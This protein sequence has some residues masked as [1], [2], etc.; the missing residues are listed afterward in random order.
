[1][2]TQRSRPSKIASPRAAQDGDSGSAVRELS[3]FAAR[4]DALYAATRAL[5]EHGD[6]EHA[7]PDL[8]RNV[9]SAL[10]WDI[11]E[12]WWRDPTREQLD[13]MG[14]WSIPELASTAFVRDTSAVNPPD[15]GLIGKVWSSGKAAWSQDVQSSSALVRAKDA[16]ESGLRSAFAF[17]ICLREDV[18]GVIAFF[19]RASRVPDQN[20]I[21]M[22]ENLGSQIGLLYERS[23]AESAIAESERRYRELVSAI[24]V[25]VYTT[26][27]E[28]RIT[29][30]NSEAEEL[31][32]R[33]PELGKDQWCGSW[34]L[35]WPDG[36]QMKHEE[37]PLAVTL[38]EQKPVTGAEIVVERSDGSRRDVL[39]HPAPLKDARGN[40]VGAVNVLID[41]SERKA[42]ERAL[43]A[44]EK[45]LRLAMEAGGLGAWEWDVKT[46]EVR[47]SATLERI[48]GIPEGSFGGT[49]EDYQRDIHPGD[50]EMVK[51]AISRS[52]Q[53]GSHELSY[54]V[55][56]PDGEVR[57]L[58]AR[59]QLHRDALG[60]P[61]RLVGVCADITDRRE[62]QERRARLAA[63]VESSDDAIIGKDLDGTITSWN[64][65]A[66]QTYGYTADE[67]IGKN[68]T[69][70]LP[71]ESRA[72]SAEILERVKRGGKVEH[73]QTRRRCKDGRI[74]DVAVTISPIRDDSGRIVGASAINRDITAAK[75]QQDFV[76]MMAQ[77][78]ASL[79][80]ASPNVRMMMAAVGRL[81]V[82]A[83]ADWCTVDLLEE[84]GTI[85]CAAV[86]HD[87][88]EKVQLALRLREEFPTIRIDSPYPL[89]E[90][91]RA[92][93]TLMEESVGPALIEDVF[94][95]QPTADALMGLGLK[96]AACVPIVSRGHILGA[97]TLATAESG[98][99][100]D[101]ETV[102]FAEELARR[103][104]LALDNVNLVRDLEASIES[105]DEFL[106][107]MS[108]ELRTPITAIYGGARLLRSRGDNFDAETR[109]Q[110][111]ADIEEESE[112]LFRMVENL[113][114]LSRVELG[115]RPPTE[116]VL[117]QRII[118][119]VVA[120]HRDR[121]PNRSI[122]VEVPGGLPPV[123]AQTTYVEQIVRNLLSNAEKYAPKDARITI[124][125]RMREGV[126]EISVSDDGPGIEPEEAQM[127][128]E[129]FY[130]IDGQEKR[131]RGL[132]LGLTVCKRLVEA[133]GGTIEAST[134]DPHGLQI[135]FT[136]P[137]SREVEV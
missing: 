30:F 54:R 71:E 41:I 113:L 120:S 32:G 82:P 20:L 130:R 103:V 16:A 91:I 36:T 57:W 43:E 2:T 63:I 121:H 92:G 114:A 74:I 15:V 129:R 83:L 21:D 23:E 94:R 17:P 118:G 33:T 56:R 109:G 37:C 49:V 131:V 55:I 26:D 35:Y 58:S 77:A 115:Q 45:R 8:L 13:L 116:P 99:R 1:M 136:L 98:R 6:V 135:T 38:R 62:A 84:D 88:P 34:R 19:T 51:D 11:G 4:A 67:I 87:D 7:A 3:T 122:E 124:A 65:G 24:G 64:R 27:A 66:E 123:D 42:A 100:F 96:S 59:G 10:G 25:A 128:F 80:A 40:L 5:V 108:H 105:K 133:M 50:L 93:K 22:M 52:L 39:P 106:G 117:A 90:V 137:V 102:S 89:A 111:L 126:V 75:R 95:H 76:A 101:R 14:R 85:A 107:L 68:V 70:I 18:L 53:T 9:C 125:A 60:Q 72:E 110:V 134:L 79:A 44:S 61:D 48:H 47:W 31:W 86:I 104:G 73:Y 132:G 97:I 127:L 78:S 12:F 29:Y 112:R 28:G 81:A 46:G 119:K 69:T